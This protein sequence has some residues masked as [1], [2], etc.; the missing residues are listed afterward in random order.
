MR[1][2]AF[3]LITLTLLI[4]NSNAQYYS[5]GADPANIKW[6]QLNSPVFKVVYPEE[7]ESEAKRF[8]AMLDSLYAY[9]GYSLDHTPKPIKVLIHAKDAYSNGFVSWAPKRMEIY[10]TPH[11][12]MLAQD[13][14]EQLA[15]HE[16]RHVVQIDKLNKGFTKVLSI[17]FG[18]QAV[19][20]VLGLYVPLW[21][22]EGDATL[23]ETTL[24]G[25]GRGR[26]PAFEQEI[27]AQ[28]LEKEIYNY[29]KA[30]FGSYKDYVPNHYN[31]G[32]LLTSGARHS[33]GADVW[34]RALDEA[35]QKSWSVTPFNRG[36]KQVTGKNKVPLYD[37]VFSQ[38]QEKWENQDDSINSDVIRTITERDQTYKN[39]RYPTVVN[40]SIIIAEVSGP[41]TVNHFSR[42]NINTG[43]EERILITGTRNREP[44]SYNNGLIV[45]TELER[46][47]RWEN[48]HYSI[49]RTY[50]LAS[51]KQKKLSSKTRFKAPALSPDGK[52]IAAVH[53]SYA[54][55]FSI[56][57]LNAE[58]GEV[59]KQ[60]QIPDNA[61]PMTPSWSQNGNS[62]VM[63]LLTKK[64]KQIA[65]LNTENNSWQTVTDAD[66]TE[67]RFP[68][69]I[70]NQIYF[71]GSYSGIENIYRINTDG[72]QLE[73]VTESKFGAAYATLSNKELIYQNYTSDG[74]IIAAS[75]ID[76]LNIK[77]YAAG[78]LPIEP[79]IEKLQKD[80]KGMPKLK[81]LTGDSYESK[82]Y[83]KWNLFNFHSWAPVFMDVDEGSINTGASLISQN[84]LGTTFTSIDFNAD[85][86]FSREKYQFKLAYRAWWPVFE[87]EFKAGDEKISQN[88]YFANATDTFRINKNA[89][90][91]H[92]LADIEMKLPLNFTR[93]KY[94]R[95]L[96]P[97]VGFTYQKSDSY[98]FDQTFV[99]I[100]DG[101]VTDKDTITYTVEGIDVKTLDYNLFAYNL[102]RS[103]QRDVASRFGQVLEMTY[104]HTPLSGRNYGSILGLHSRLYFPGVGR[105]HSIRINNDWQIKQRGEQVKRDG[106]TYNIYRTL[107][108]YI[109]FPRGISRYN[110]DQLYSLKADYI[111][112]LI[113][114][115]F[116]IKG[117]MYL[118][119]ITMNLFYDYSK[120]QQD[121]QYSDTGDWVTAKGDFQSLGTELRAEFHPFRFVF[122]M[123]AGYR[124]AYLPDT[125]EHY[126]EAL[127]SFG[128][129]GIV[130]GEK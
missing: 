47:P 30:Y 55:E 71:T 23:T 59:I 8:I 6:R 31:M 38:W 35:G 10:P 4:C 119:R 66:F 39:Y 118:K 61:Y 74:Y 27:R 98:T 79:F 60:I 117:I 126:H 115:D 85:K 91:N 50:E 58:N 108:D 63:I 12:D 14:L 43:E 89:Q 123:T 41:G 16:F 52:T 129:S 42:I 1:K 122:P 46:H 40:D 86:Q 13:W 95:N 80:E 78:K 105:H 77:P 76:G 3:I 72:T 81:H 106:T 37:E 24:S 2:L 107:P 93:G 101:I 33:Y 97:S 73:K 125:G 120:A 44:F 121:L 103:T 113:N 20:A 56:H 28:V 112:P 109:S 49:I 64:G 124:Y 15:I 70:N 17:P 25:A 99:S 102:L 100:N 48:Q 69:I 114:P 84:L 57:L 127:V 53:A 29:D 104:R 45:W 21:F 11:Q 51:K 5:S 111:M 22:L 128:I 96:Q 67:I 18:Q 75:S 9:G 65:L 110:N 87:L 54:N 34:E 82:K 92:F 68:K 62:L 94:Y 36:I 32:Y 19:G 130:T 90:P 83:S 88:G 7:F 116:N 26:R